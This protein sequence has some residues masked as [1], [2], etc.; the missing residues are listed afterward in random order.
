MS[1]LRGK[2]SYRW[3]TAIVAFIALSAILAVSYADSWL[4]RRPLRERYDFSSVMRTDLDPIL[5]AP[6]RLESSKRTVVRCQLENITGSRAGGGGASTV[7]FLLP[8]GTAVKKGDLLAKLDS[9]SYEELQRQ[10]VITVEQA[11]ASHLQAKLNHEI[12]LLAVHEYRDGIVEQTLKGMEGSIALAKSDLSRCTEHLGW[13][14][15]MRD[16]GYTSLAQI[17]TERHSVSQM[18]IALNRQLSARDL[19][20]RFS[21]PKTEKTLERQVTAAK[22]TLMNEELR[23]QRQLDRLE[24][25][26]K[27]VEYCSIRAPHDGSLYYYKDPNPRSRNPTVIEEGMAVRQRQALFYLPDLNEMEVQVA[28]NESVVNRVKPGLRAK[29]RFEALPDVELEGELVNVGQMPAGQAADGEDIRYFI[30]LVK[31]DR[32]VPGLTPGMTTRV[33]IALPGCDHVLAVPHEAIKTVNGKKICFVAHDE[34]LQKRQIEI[35]QETASL[36]EVTGGLEEGEMVVL[37]PPF[38][39]VHGETSP[40]F[41]DIETDPPADTANVASAH[42]G[43]SSPSASTAK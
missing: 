30:S 27:Q 34:T 9:A 6:G 38:N 2:H 12:A 11:K 7:L 16:K 3:A 4:D 22:T 43:H 10:Q 8:E 39:A 5:N 20:Q 19:F 24:V 23:L 31:L 42:P 14:E 29:V 35:G 37:N 25:L 40:D 18:E 26:N 15:H 32:S 1:W 13:T 33:D 41:D 28:L 36:V 17:L 21:Q